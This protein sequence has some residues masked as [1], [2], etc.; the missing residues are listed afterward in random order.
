MATVA[1]RRTREEGAGCD[2][3]QARLSEALALAVAGQKDR[4]RCQRPPRM[5]F[6]GLWTATAEKAL[7]HPYSAKDRQHLDD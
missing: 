6:G 3:D 1:R 7:I 4:D 5:E 2:G